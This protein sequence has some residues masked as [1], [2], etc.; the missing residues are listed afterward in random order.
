MK[1]WSRLVEK[2]RLLKKIRFRVKG[3][4]KLLNRHGRGKKIVASRRRQIFKVQS[5]FGRVGGYRTD[6]L[7]R[8][9]IPIQRRLVFRKKKP[10]SNWSRLG[11]YD[12]NPCNTVLPVIS[13]NVNGL[14]SANLNI[15]TNRPR[16]AI[17]I[18]TTSRGMKLSNVQNL[19]M[20]TRV[21]PSFL[22]SLG[23]DQCKFDY[24]FYLG[25]DVGDAFYDNPS[26]KQQYAN[27]FASQAQKY[28]RVRLAKF[29]SCHGTS[30]APCYVWNQLFLEAYRDNND[31]FY[32]IGDDC[33]FITQGWTS[34]FVD[35]LRQD[36][37]ELGVTGPLDINNTGLMTQSFVSRTH[38]KIFD[39][40]Y[41][42]AFKN[43]YCDNWLVDVYKD[44]GLHKWQKGY[45]VRN[46]PQPERYSIQRWSA[47]DLKAVVENYKR[48]LVAWRVRPIKLSIMICSVDARWYF[49]S[50][51][52]HLL[53]QQ[54]LNCA[55]GNDTQNLCTL[56]N[57]IE[58]VID[59]GAPNA[60][61]IGEKR[62]RLISNSR[63]E[64]V[65]FVDDDDLV[66]TSYIPL[67]V[68]KL[69][70]HAGVDC[71]NLKGHMYTN[72]KFIK[73]FVHSVIHKEWKE[74]PKEYCRPPNHL[75]PI[76][77]SIVTRFPFRHIN[78][79]EDRDFS[80]RI[81]SSLKN[82]AKI[83]DCLYYYLYVAKK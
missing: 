77:R 11:I 58:I 65:C 22:N 30:H 17:L 3:K 14:S 76:R 16:V 4:H 75:N 64:F 5:M 9:R 60:I 33:E 44:F 39:T 78:K 68:N 42:R 35:V 7:V 8:R 26:R 18:P 36:V 40:Y 53:H 83:E 73:P 47:S 45:Q 27:L 59:Y 34:A 70:S 48:K 71:I 21:F 81:S 74:T 49:L 61:T 57:Q 43:W 23:N 56:E 15:Q 28:P 79:G 62:N 31:Y 72:G 10:A 12:P 24:N 52:R 67:V 82:E 19:D 13:Y 38:M 66:N 2:Y 51:L 69:A 25:C 55:T 20:F 50:R 46:K 54:T 41:P 29:M 80:L 32:Q 6:S 37:N 1:Y 63:G